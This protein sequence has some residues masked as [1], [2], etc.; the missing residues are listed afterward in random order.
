MDCLRLILIEG[1][2]SPKSPFLGAM[3]A[4]LQNHGEHDYSPF[5]QSLV[6]IE[7]CSPSI[8]IL[9]TSELPPQLIILTPPQQPNSTNETTT[10]MKTTTIKQQQ[11]DQQRNQQPQH[12]QPQE[13]PQQSNN[14]N[15]TMI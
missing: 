9:P 11:Q 10:T 12:N 4:K 14:N 6:E 3:S 7:F 2:H 13:Q 1:D 8:S 15:K 5:G